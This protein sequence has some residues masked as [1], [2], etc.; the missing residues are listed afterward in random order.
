MCLVTQAF[1][2]V[3]VHCAMLLVALHMNVHVLDYRVGKRNCYIYPQ[4]GVPNLPHSGHKVMALTG[5][6]GIMG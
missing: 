4:Q 3:H 2:H 6:A 5:V 1:M